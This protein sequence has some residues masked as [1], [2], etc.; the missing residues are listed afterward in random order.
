MPKVESLSAQE[1][2][3]TVT[4][5]DDDELVHIWSAQRRQIT[6]MRKDS[7]FT[8]VAC[9]FYGTTEWAEFTIPADRWS[10]LG[11]KRTRTMTTA[12]RQEAAER[13]AGVRQGAASPTTQ[14]A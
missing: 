10:P 3:T 5:C 1:R 12:Q 9:G 4:T 14:S 2:E 11:V 6:K 13:L 8:E 7:A